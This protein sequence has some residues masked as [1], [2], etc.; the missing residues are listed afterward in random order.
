MSKRRLRIDVAAALLAAMAWLAATWGCGE[1]AKPEGVAGLFPDPA[2]VAGVDGIGEIEMYRDHTLYDFLNGG[3]ELY[4]DYGIVSVA[5]AEY[6]SS[7]DKSIE[8][9]I[10]D[11]GDSAGAFGIYSN[12]RYARADF[13]DIGNEGILTGS[14]LD[15]W[16]GRYYCRL[17][18]FGTAPGTGNVLLA[19]GEAVS[20]NIA[21][22]GSLPDIIGLL[23]ARNRVLRSEKYFTGPVALNNIHYVGAGNVLAL[24]ENTRG[25][26]AL[27]QVGGGASTAFLIEYATVDDAEAALSAYRAGQD[28]R[29]APLAER[30]GRYIAGVWDVESPGAATELLE[31][32]LDSLDGQ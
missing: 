28:A 5:S 6:V 24:G 32:L 27:Y 14:S 29:R 18:T 15:F 26:A 21:A 23:P 11:M 7:G 9:S 1:R 25:A 30:R 4:F 10:Y 22:R 31:D 2:G 17:L 3:A 16:K 8:L 19:L 20:G 13:V 12:M